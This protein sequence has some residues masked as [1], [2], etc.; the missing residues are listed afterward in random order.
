MRQT[1]GRTAKTASVS[2]PEDAAKWLEKRVRDLKPKV[3]GI[4]HYVQLLIELDR[5]KNLLDAEGIR[6]FSY[7]VVAQAA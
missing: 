1:T 6:P 2:L 3:K 4:S 5:R 7:G